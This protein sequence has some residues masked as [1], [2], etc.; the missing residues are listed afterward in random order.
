MKK[1]M[2]GMT[3][4]EA[5][6]FLRE[7][8]Y[9]YRGETKGPLPI[10]TYFDRGSYEGYSRISVRSEGYGDS[11]AAEIWCVC[12]GTEAYEYYKLGEWAK[13]KQR[14]SRFAAFMV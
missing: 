1:T 10:N 7:A 8:G 6:N 11:A 2:W 9:A 4:R 13:D 3:R 5:F 12:D 14:L